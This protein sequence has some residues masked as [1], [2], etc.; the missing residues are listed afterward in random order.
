MKDKKDLNTGSDN[1]S[2]SMRLSVVMICALVLAIAIIPTVSA[3]ITDNSVGIACRFLDSADNPLVNAD[4]NVSIYDAASGGNQLYNEVFTNATDS[5]GYCTIDYLFDQ[6]AISVTQGDVLFLDLTVDGEDFDFNGVERKEFNAWF[7]STDTTG[8]VVGNGTVLDYVALGNGAI[9]GGAESGNAKAVAIGEDARADTNFGNG[10]VAIGRSSYSHEFAVGIGDDASASQTQSIAIGSTARALQN[11]AIAI[12]ANTESDSPNAIV[13]GTNAFARYS[14]NMNGFAI[15]TN[16]RAENAGSNDDNMM[17][18]GHSALANRQDTTAIGRESSATAPDAVAFGTGVVASNTGAVSIGHSITNSQVD[19]LLVGR[20]SNEWIRA[21]SSGVYASNGTVANQ[22]LATQSYVTANAG[23]AF[24]AGVAGSIQY[25]NGTDF[26]GSN[27]L[28]YGNNVDGFVDGFETPNALLG[29]YTTTNPYDSIALVGDRNNNYNALYIQP[30]GVFLD[31]YDT[32]GTFQFN[33]YNDIIRLS[34]GT[35]PQYIDLN[36]SN[37]NGSQVILPASGTL[38]TES[39]VLA[40]AGGVDESANYTWT[41]THNYTGATVEGLLAPD[42][43][44]SSLSGVVTGVGNAGTSI[45]LGTSSSAG[46]TNSVSIG[47]SNSASGVNGVSIGSFSSAGNTNSIGI[48]ANADA[49]GARSVALGSDVTNSQADSL[50]FETSVVNNILRVNSTGVYSMGLLLAT[51]N[52][53]LANAVVNESANYNWTGNH[54]YQEPIVHAQNGVVR[55]FANGCTET[56]N[57]T[58]VFITC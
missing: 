36:I 8:I 34:H 33:V 7:G 21:N 58:G 24:P 41:G 1:K 17:A 47:N 32:A 15:G 30:D 20:N 5:N 51:E 31:Q 14:I 26:A 44:G 35:N 45:N 57:A 56:A 10:G 38:A 18:V 48:G 12:G 3:A 43:D 25:S 9:M 53:V 23:G 29:A 46:G 49:T 16:A 42:G 27:N 19:S 13:I 2:Y 22:Q 55:T 50:L 54:T 6:S 40:N 4:I 39:F 11:N 37:G 52:F 28:T